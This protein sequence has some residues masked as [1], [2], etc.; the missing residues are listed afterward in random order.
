[1]Y[2]HS[3]RDMLADAAEKL[4]A[5]L[6]DLQEVRKIEAGCSTGVDSDRA[7]VTL[8]T[9]IRDSGFADALVAETEGGAGLTLQE[10]AP[11]VFACGR[12]T[13]PLPLAH[14]MVVRAAL[15]D[16]GVAIPDGSITIASYTAFNAEGGV[17]VPAVP[18]GMVADWVLAR[19]ADLFWLLPVSA[20]KRSP[21][22][23]FGKLAADLRWE[24]K[25]SSALCLGSA[26][27][28]GVVDFQALA[29]AL[30]AALMASAMKRIGDMSVGYANDRVQ[31]G[32]PIGKLQAIQQQLAV[33]AEL[34]AASGC[35]AELGL[36]PESGSRWKP[37]LLRC[38]VAKARVSEA[39][40]TCAS[41]AH[42]VHGAIGVS[43]EYDLQVLIRHL[44]DWRL[45]YGSE[46]HWNETVGRALVGNNGKSAHQFAA[47]LAD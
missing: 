21:T 36:M 11:V 16:Q 37:N 45:Q 34:I 19:H 7:I 8:W 26:I 2:T 38:A 33:M 23:G 13:V 20:A 46:S 42:A 43:E 15:A 17:E 5:D 3:E 12:H 31:F 30:T 41:I 4:L 35:A 39:A 25:P 29:A 27:E 18:Y 44:Q 47:T 6:S 24:G 9:A 32:K 1:M 14:T 28:S 40:T 22:H 10:V